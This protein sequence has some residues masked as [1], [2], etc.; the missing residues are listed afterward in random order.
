MSTFHYRIYYKF[1]GPS[2]DDP[3]ATKPLSDDE[4]QPYV[5]ELRLE[6]PNDFSIANEGNALR[7]SASTIKSEQDT[8]DLLERYV[9]G[10]NRRTPR[11]SLI[12]DK[13]PAH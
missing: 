2:K 1:L 5:D 12:I 4:V 3:F 11:L 10:I 9:A 8:D 6:L 7:I 13:L